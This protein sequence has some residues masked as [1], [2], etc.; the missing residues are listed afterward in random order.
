MDI[1]KRMK[2]NDEQENEQEHFNIGDVV[3]L[4]SERRCMTVS[5]VCTYI[6]CVWMNG[7]TLEVEDFH[8]SILTHEPHLGDLPF[9]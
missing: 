8:Y 9:D 6:T 5:I 3:R 4:K 7:D 2:N 1:G